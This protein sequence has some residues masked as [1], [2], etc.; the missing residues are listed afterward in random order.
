MSLDQ[1]MSTVYV[2]T[3]WTNN[4]GTWEPEVYANLEDAQ[5]SFKYYVDE[6][7]ATYEDDPEGLYFAECDEGTFWIQQCEVN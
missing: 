1:I 3:G 7:Y 2:I 5:Q 4:C 6:Y